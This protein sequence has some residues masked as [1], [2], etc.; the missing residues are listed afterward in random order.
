MRKPARLS[1]SGYS[2]EQDSTLGLDRKLN[3]PFADR[4]PLPLPL[5]FYASSV[6]P[7]LVEVGRLYRSRTGARGLRARG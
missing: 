5:L 1:A 6:Y 7:V 4:R 2:F 3:A